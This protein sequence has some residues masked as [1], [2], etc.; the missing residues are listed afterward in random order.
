VATGTPARFRRVHQAAPAAGT[1]PRRSADSLAK[2]WLVGVIERTPLEEVA[3][4][5]VE[6]LAEEA[7]PLITAILEALDDPGRPGVALADEALQRARGLGGLRRGEP[8]SPEVSRDLAALHSLLIAALERDV[9]APQPADV[10]RAAGRLAEIFGALQGAVTESLVRDRSGTARRDDVA[11]LPDD[12]DLQRWLQ[13]LAAEYRRYGH[14]FAVALVDVEGLAPINEVYGRQSG[15]WMLT[16]VG[17]VIRNQIRIVDHAFRLGED[18]FCVLAPNVDALRL[19]PMADRLARVVETSQSGDA[20]RIA[21]S[22][23]VSGCPEHGHDTGHLIEVA[24]EA[25]YTAKA[26]GQPVEVAASNGARGA[27]LA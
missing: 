11:R 8:A 25:L 18:G 9:P 1:D 7:A 24:E 20:P 3:E 13:V 10:S 15:T 19:R 5:D 17:T 26:A 12:A 22:V 23:G 27:A 21:I 4:V 14:P 16:A 6:L 2:A